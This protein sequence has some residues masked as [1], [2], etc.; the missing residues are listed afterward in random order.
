MLAYFG[1][2]P[3]P[4]G[5]VAASRTLEELAAAAKRCEA[6]PY[7]IGK[8]GFLFG[9]GNADSPKAVFIVG[10]QGKAAG[11]SGAYPPAQEAEFLVTM[12][13]KGFRIS[14]EDCYLTPAFK[15]A[16]PP[17]AT[18][19]PGF[20]K[21]WATECCGHILKRQLELLRP[22]A[23][24]AL[25]TDAA[26]VATGLRVPVGIHRLMGRPV[27]SAG[28]WS[29]G[30]WVTYGLDGMLASPAVKIEAWKDLRSLS[31]FLRS[32]VN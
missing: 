6:C 31:A 19:L 10:R 28:P 21:D 8:T 14:E 3:D 32:S 11:R 12:L 30:L 24:A 25:G 26:G 2:P 29:A 18:G 22:R 5:W 20:A 1:P 13:E 7:S 9:R 15:C 27:I 23:V 17:P 4:P 16:G